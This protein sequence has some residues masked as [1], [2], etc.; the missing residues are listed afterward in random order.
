MADENDCSKHGPRK[1]TNLGQT[2]IRGQVRDVI[3]TDPCTGC[4]AEEAAWWT[5]RRLQLQEILVQ[6]MLGQIN[7]REAILQVEVLG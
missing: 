4:V 2:T 5:P 7:N 1:V 3:R 6:L